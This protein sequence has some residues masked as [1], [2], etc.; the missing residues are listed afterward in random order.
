MIFLDR[1]P[2]KSSF[3]SSNRLKYR[4]LAAF[5]LSEAN[6]KQKNKGA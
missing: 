3:V 6:L 5:R 4:V 2:L 1:N